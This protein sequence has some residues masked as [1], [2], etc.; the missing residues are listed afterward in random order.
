MSVPEREREK[1]EQSDPVVSHH[2]EADRGHRGGAHQ[3][4]EA[5]VLPRP[6]LPP[7]RPADRPRGQE[8]HRQH[9]H[10]VDV[11]AGEHQGRGGDNG[12]QVPHGRA[13]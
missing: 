5:R 11:R 4:G 9:D 6:D 12:E 2:D 10:V 7:A 3:R 13:A 8:E 1:T